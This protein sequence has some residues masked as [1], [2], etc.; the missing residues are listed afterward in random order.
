MTAFHLVRSDGAG[1]VDLVHTGTGKVYVRCEPYYDLWPLR[2]HVTHWMIWPHWLPR[3]VR[4]AFARKR[5]T[6][7]IGH[8]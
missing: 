3:C 7:W 1:A 4:W 5:E 2:R 6:N 8:T